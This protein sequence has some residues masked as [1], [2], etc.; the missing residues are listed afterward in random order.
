MAI[1]HESIPLTAREAASG[2][3]GSVSMTC[4][5]FLLVRISHLFASAP[6]TNQ[7]PQLIENYRNGNAEA[8]SLLFVFVWFVGDIANLAGGLLAGLVP[9]IVAIAVYFCIADGVLI[10]QCLYYKARNARQPVHRRRSSTETPDPTTPLLGRRFSDSLGSSQG[11]RR[12]SGSQ[13]GY[14]AG[15]RE[16]Q[17]EDTLAKIVEENDF[18]RKAWF[19]NVASVL[20]IFVVGMAGWTMAWQTGMW[21]P[22]P[23]EDNNGSDEATGGLMLGYFSAVC[24]LGYVW[25]FYFWVLMG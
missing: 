17:V 5:I 3:L 6:L 8:I 7:V 11:R 15:R 9:V 13:R 12:S 20:G 4:W 22:A 25:F 16:S 1:T 18:G 23:V 24:Y 10:A 14:G 19:K 21:E 2:L